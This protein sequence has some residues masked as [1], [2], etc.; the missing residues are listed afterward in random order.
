MAAAEQRETELEARRADVIASR[1]R[2]QR[3]RAVIAALPPIPRAPGG[4]GHPLE[5]LRAWREAA[6]AAVLPRV[7]D[8]RA[9][10]A[11][12]EREARRAQERAGWDPSISTEPFVADGLRDF[13]RR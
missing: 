11:T 6:D 8:D 1:A 12:W 5:D 7:Q 13:Q 4:D 10:L 9:M 3:V 2:T